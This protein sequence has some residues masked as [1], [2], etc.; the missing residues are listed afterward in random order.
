MYIWESKS[1]SRS[2]MEG[3]TLESKKPG[4]MRYITDLFFKSVL[5]FKLQYSEDLDCDIVDIT[6]LK[7]IN[8]S[9]YYYLS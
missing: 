3:L 5:I 9:D 7:L 8:L 2:I 1:V 6:K 4:F